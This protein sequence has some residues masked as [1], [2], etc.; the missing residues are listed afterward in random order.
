MP[1]Y[2]VGPDSKTIAPL[3]AMKNRKTCRASRQPHITFPPAE[4]AGTSIAEEGAV[5]GGT[6][7]S[8]TL[9]DLTA[10]ESIA[11]SFDAAGS[12]TPDS[13]TTSSHSISIHQRARNA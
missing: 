12:D 1:A 13:L 6:F 11:P 7:D 4:M 5:L 2:R 3:K 8:A 10:A 9:A